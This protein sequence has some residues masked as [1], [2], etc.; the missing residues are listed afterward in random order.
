VAWVRSRP[1]LD[2]TQPRTVTI[3]GHTGKM[4]DVSLAATGAGSC[5]DMSD[6]IDVYLTYAS[7]GSDAWTWGTQGAERQRLIF[8]DLGAGDVVLIGIDSTDPAR[9]DQLV[10]DAMPIVQSLTFK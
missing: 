5:P 9:Y 8:L 10:N 4:V 1:D 6:P 2:S 3:D 7:G